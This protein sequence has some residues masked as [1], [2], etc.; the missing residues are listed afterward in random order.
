MVN[1]C[2]LFDIGQEEG[3]LPIGVGV[4]ASFGYLQSGAFNAYFGQKGKKD[5]FDGVNGWVNFIVSY[6]SEGEG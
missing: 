1:R 6:S 4:K 2:D 3:Y 5:F